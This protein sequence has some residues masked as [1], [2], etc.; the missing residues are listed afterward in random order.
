MK[1]RETDE[2]V[3]N[4]LNDL[5]QMVVRTAIRRDSKMKG[6]TKTKKEQGVV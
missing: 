3:N 6:R 1:S 2:T 5:G 4:I